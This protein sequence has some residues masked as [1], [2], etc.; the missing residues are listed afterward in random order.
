MGKIGCGYGSEWHLLRY[1]GYH[2][3]V[4]EE[5]ILKNTGGDQVTWLDFKFSNRNE[6]LNRDR[7]WK[8]VEFLDE[9]TQKEWKAWWPQTGNIQNWD[10]VGR[11]HIGDS[12]EWLL[13]EAKAHIN[14][15]KNGCGAKSKES[16]EKIV[17]N[18]MET[19]KS[20][21]VKD[22]PLKNWLEPYYQLC[23]R[24]AVLHFL[25]CECKPPVTSRLIMIYFYG[26]QVTSKNCPQSLEEWKTELMLMYD[27]VGL[28]PKSALSDKIHTIFLSVNPNVN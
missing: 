2:R 11:L 21:N 24:L 17:S 8:G 12:V 9:R 14:E 3:S 13:F 28:D 1:L 19:M 4:L 20:F 27:W 26:D 10:A 25:H 5:E 6:P 23:N 22:A 16:K 15:L 18:F 7:E